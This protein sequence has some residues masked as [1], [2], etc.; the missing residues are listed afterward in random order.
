[1]TYVFQVLFRW[2]VRAIGL[3]HGGLQ[4]WRCT[5]MRMRAR[6]PFVTLCIDCSTG[7]KHQYYRS[8]LSSS[9]RV[10]S[11]YPRYPC[12]RLTR[13]HA[14]LAR[15]PVDVTGTFSPTTTRAEDSTFSRAVPRR[16]DGRLAFGL[17]DLNPSLERLSNESWVWCSFRWTTP[18][19]TTELVSV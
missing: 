12:L 14:M 9:M 18:Y 2:N 3:H 17:R 4:N 16:L 6:W 7:G 13:R 5:T 1:M 10:D 19:G 15:H 8:R 11:K